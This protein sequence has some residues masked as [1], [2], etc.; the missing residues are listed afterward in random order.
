MFALRDRG[1]DYSLYAAARG[2]A[3]ESADGLFTVFFFAV[4]DS[5]LPSLAKPEIS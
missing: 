2:F 1:A 3:V 5:T 4:R